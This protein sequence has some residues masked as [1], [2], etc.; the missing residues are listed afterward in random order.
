MRLADRSI[1]GMLDVSAVFYVAGP[2]NLVVMVWLRHPADLPDFEV[3]LTMRAP[4]AVIADCMVTHRAVKHVG[5]LLDEQGRWI[6]RF[7]GLPATSLL[8]VRA[9]TDAVSQRTSASARLI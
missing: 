4:A 5:R 1:A 6:Q 2:Q 7:S 8:R 3:Q 9:S